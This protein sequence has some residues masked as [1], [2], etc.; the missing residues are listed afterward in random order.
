M[1]D[2][3][4]PDNWDWDNATVHAAVPAHLRATWFGVRFE[5]DDGQRVA[6][7]AEELGVT[8]TE[9]IRRLVLDDLSLPAVKA[10]MT[11]GN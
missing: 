11:Y 10:R 4:N 1:D 9:Y 3:K 7:R 6:A 2:L 8:A 5:G